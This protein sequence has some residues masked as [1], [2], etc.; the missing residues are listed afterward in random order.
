MSGNQNLPNNYFKSYREKLFETICSN[1]ETEIFPY[2]IAL[3]ADIDQGLIL[4][5][6]IY[7]KR[8]KMQQNYE[9]T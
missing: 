9:K 4:L 3:F 2:T 7:R 5:R 8:K 6:H 1:N